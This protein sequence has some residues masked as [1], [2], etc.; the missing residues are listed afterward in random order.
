[1]LKRFNLDFSKEGEKEGES[2]RYESSEDAP[3]K[4][5]TPPLTTESKGDEQEAPPEE[6]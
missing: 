5:G 4:D 2:D 1:V 3:A 6:K